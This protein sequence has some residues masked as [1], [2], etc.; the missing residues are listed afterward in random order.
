MSDGSQF[1]TFGSISCFIF[2]NSSIINTDLAELFQQPTLMHNFLYSLTICSLHYYPRHVS[3][4]NMPIFRRKNC[5]HTA[6]GIFALCKR[7]H[8]TLVESRLFQNVATEVPVSTTS[9]P[10]RQFSGSLIDCYIFWSWYRSCTSFNL[11]MHSARLNVVKLS[12]DG[13]ASWPET[14]ALSNSGQLSIPS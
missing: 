10:I 11:R 1:G 14:A 13:A 4:I 9:Y 3:S 5:L 2:K 6:S 12:K 7:L 8:S